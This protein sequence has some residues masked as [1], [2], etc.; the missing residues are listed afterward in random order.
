MLCQPLIW[1]FIPHPYLKSLGNIIE[2]KS[3]NCMSQRD[4][5]SRKEYL[6]DIIDLHVN[7]QLL[8]L[9]RQALHRIEPITVPARA[10]VKDIKV[11][12]YQETP[13]NNG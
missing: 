9:H 3:E 7:S 6:P 4:F 12:S 2:K 10:G 13:G 1:I 11:P 5:G 8:R